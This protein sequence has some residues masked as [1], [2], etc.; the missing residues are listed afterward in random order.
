VIRQ[1]YIL[2]KQSRNL[3]GRAIVEVWVSTNEGPVCLQSPPQQPLCFANQLQS[4]ALVELAEQEGI[5]VTF[6][7]DGFRTLEQ[8]PVD[9][10]K[11]TSEIH[12]H[13]LRQLASRESITLYEADV[14]LA[15]RYLMERFIY[16]AL[17]FSA[18]DK[19]TSVIKNA[20]VRPAN[21]SPT[22]AS[23]SIDIECDEHEN[24]F[25]VA[26]ASTFHNEVLLI[27]NPAHPAS[28]P[29]SL[30]A[31]SLFTLTVVDSER[32]LLENFIQRVNQLDPDVILGWNI[33]QFDMA[34][35][36]RRAK[37][38]NVKFSM[39]RQGRDV[40]VRQW[41]GQALV[42]IPGRCVIDGIESLKTMTYQFDSF[43]LDNIAQQLL[44]D[45]KLIQSEDKLA[46]IKNLYYDNPCALAEY[47]HKDCV[48]VNEIAAKTGFIDFLLLRG[49]L[50]GLDLGRPGGSVAAFL[51]VYLPKLH[52]RKYVSGVRPEHGGLASPGGYVMDSQPGLYQDVLV[53]DF[54][55]LYPS[56]IR[57]FKIDPMGLAE[58]LKQPHSAINGFKGAMF[59]RE[60]H[61][62]PDI[63]SNLWLQRD[64]AKRQHDAPR[65]QAIKILMNSF[66]GV[67]GSG[68]CPFYDPR[69]ASSITMR[70]HD[71]MQ[72][73]AKWIEE[74]GYRVIYGDTDSTFVHIN[75]NSALSSPE[76]I[77]NTLACHIN[78]KWIEKL[79]NEFD[80]EC[81]LEIEFETHFETFFMPTI[82][83][84]ALGSKK[85]YAGLKRHNNE[86][87]L[88]FK[89]LEN[90]RSDW[91]ELA[92]HFQYELYKRVF[93]EKPV[94]DFIKDTVASIRQGQEDHRLVYSK[95]LR[96]PLNAYVKALPPHVKAAIHADAINIKDGNR[97]RYQNNTSIRYV[98]T[99]QGPQTIE[100]QI[101][102]LDYDHYIEKQIMPIADSLLPQI[103]LSFSSLIDEQLEL[104][105]D[106]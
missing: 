76:D 80:I 27:S 101:A 4:E 52:R 14:R 102:P 74:L 32:A 50:T 54:K 96:K 47:N 90:V 28:F 38:N 41:E 25:S 93:E 63:I 6:Y 79:K 22:L 64:E 89:G 5:E 65:S 62:L 7:K 98:I 29:A 26:I 16:G 19:K 56:I 20:R 103:G 15:D 51:N 42:D 57:T 31:S 21:Y 17:E 12:M 46:A 34:V 3:A 13:Q 71:I 78:K 39:G 49:T 2:S 37:Y 97:L 73:T 95:R 40:H 10:L 24:L 88:V 87:E 82:R 53:L 45:T 75:D 84:S 83:G 1:G 11:T 44:G 30:P 60:H 100:H 91:T 72:T 55:S 36:A 106:K 66:Y 18:P 77:G 23:I 86:T 92:K 35:L 9:T 58:G 68:G 105:N 67:L 43:S 99:V 81:Y 8:T 61:F 85:R 94:S 33:K 59:S 70:G 48:L 69:L 104:F